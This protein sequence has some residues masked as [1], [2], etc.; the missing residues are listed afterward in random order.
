VDDE[1]QLRQFIETRSGAL[2]RSAYLLVG[3]RTQAEDLLQTALIKTYLAW[4]RIR[5]HGAVEAYVRRTMATTATSWWRG[6]RYRERSADVVPD[7]VEEDPVG[8]AIERDTMWALLR[9]LPPRQRAVL[10]LRYYEG[11]SEAEI[12]DTLRMAR[13]TVKGYAA[14]ALATLRSRIARQTTIEDHR[15]GVQR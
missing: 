14:R 2:L 15:T 3:D 6:R 5:D 13:G 4:P 7:R 10:V 9:S 1:D 11:L 8:P 12:A